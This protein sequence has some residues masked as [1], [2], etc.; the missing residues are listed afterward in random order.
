MGPQMACGFC[1]PLGEMKQVK[2]DL[3]GRDTVK[4]SVITFSA[5]N[6]Y[7]VWTDELEIRAGSRSADA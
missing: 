7:V 4:S 2:I 1:C 5:E 3:N 6:A